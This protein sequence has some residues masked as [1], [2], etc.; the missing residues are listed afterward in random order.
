MAACIGEEGKLGSLVHAP[1]E[2]FPEVAVVAESFADPWWNTGR[3]F[4]ARVKASVLC[5]VVVDW[6]GDGGAGIE[7]GWS[8]PQ[9]CDGEKLRDGFHGHTR[10]GDR[11][12]CGNCFGI[13]L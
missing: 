1:S 6:V 13:C 12:G 11:V 3:P 10:T 4:A 5:G 7:H 2:S 9:Y 8:D